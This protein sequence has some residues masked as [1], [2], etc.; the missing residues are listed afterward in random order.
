VRLSDNGTFGLATIHREHVT[1]D[2]DWI[3]FEYTAKG[4]KQREQAVAD[5]QVCAVVRGL[6]R[7]ASRRIAR[8]LACF[9]APAPGS[10]TG[11]A[12]PEGAGEELDSRS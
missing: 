2:R 5:E 4:A 7:A 9:S 12:R 11:R 1:C 8:R 6:K 10:G 3:V